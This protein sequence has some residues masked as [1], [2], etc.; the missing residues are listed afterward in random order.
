MLQDFLN[1]IKEHEEFQL[2]IGM[3]MRITLKYDL[4]FT[5]TGLLQE[6]GVIYQMVVI[7]K[8][9]VYILDTMTEFIM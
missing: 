3:L 7:K 2:K 8:I 9:V 1:D 6:H 5:K 4:S